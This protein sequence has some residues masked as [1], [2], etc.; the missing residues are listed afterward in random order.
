MI[1]SVLRSLGLDHAGEEDNEEDAE[2]EREHVDDQDGEGPPSEARHHS[3]NWGKSKSDGR[4]YMSRPFSIRRVCRHN[5]LF[6]FQFSTLCNII[7]SVTSTNKLVH[8][9]F[10]IHDVIHEYPLLHVDKRSSPGTSLMIN[11]NIARIVNAAHC[12]S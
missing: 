3:P 12:H 6:Y 4:Q 11:T 9:S 8:N 2:G 10:F 5:R 1:F 7:L